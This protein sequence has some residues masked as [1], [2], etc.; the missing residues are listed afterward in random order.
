M[1]GNEAGVSSD[2][3]AMDYVRDRIRQQISDSDVAAIDA[4]LEELTVAVADG[5][6][7][8]AADAANALREVMAGI[9]P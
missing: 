6:L 3:F 4:L 7:A 5:D 1:N 2:A 8:A 9:A